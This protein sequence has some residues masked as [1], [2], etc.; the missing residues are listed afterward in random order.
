MSEEAQQERNSRKAR[1][2]TVVSDKTDKT[3]VVMVERQFADRLYGKRMKR[4][5]KYHAHDETNEYRVGDTVRIVETR[6]ISKLKRWR[7]AELIER[8]Q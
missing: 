1:V 5:A 2:G 3:V 7:V 6:P 4:S 8:P